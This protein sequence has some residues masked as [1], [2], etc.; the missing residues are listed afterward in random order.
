MTKRGLAAKVLA[1]KTRRTE[2]RASA[3]EAV[4]IREP[5]VY[6]G[7]EE[8]PELAKIFERYHEPCEVI[9]NVE[10]WGTR[11]QS[12]VAITDKLTLKH[13]QCSATSFKVMLQKD[14][15]KKGIHEV[16]IYEYGCNTR[17]K[18]SRCPKF[19][20]HEEDAKTAKKTAKMAK[21][22]EEEEE[23]EADPSA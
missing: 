19:K 9:A 12:L 21:K 2:E 20:L 17:E 18:L 11:E 8:D 23:S 4:S 22:L 7:D 14:I 1:R 10:F 16:P 15:L 13:L 3:R 6:L 5:E